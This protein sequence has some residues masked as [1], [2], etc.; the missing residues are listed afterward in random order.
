MSRLT[1]QT[2]GLD[3]QDLY[4][5]QHRQA[6]ACEQLAGLKVLELLC[7]HG[8][9][10]AALMSI[11]AEVDGIDPDGDAINRAK[12]LHGNLGSLVFHTANLDNLPFVDGV[13]DAVVSFSDLAQA[14]RR[15]ALIEEMRRV[16]KPE[17]F[18]LVCLDATVGTDIDAWEGALSK[19]FSGVAAY[20]QRIVAASSLAPL[21][22][23]RPAPNG[24]D[25]RGYR[26]IL[27]GGNPSK[28]GP[29]V[30]RFNDPTSFVYLASNAPLPHIDGP[31]S[32]F[33]ME[34]IDLWA[35]RTQTE[36]RKSKPDDLK[37]EL[38]MAR[39]KIAT[40][41][42]TRDSLERVLAGR[43]EGVSGARS[44]DLS[45]AR[46]MMEELA[47]KPVPADV[48]NLIKLLGQIGVDNT[49][50]DMRLS[51]AHKEI[52]A[53]TAAQ[54]DLISNLEAISADAERQAVLLRDAA[55]KCEEVSAILAEQIKQ[56]S[57]LLTEILQDLDQ[58][59]ERESVAVQ[60][61]R[62]LAA[63]SDELEALLARGRVIEREFAVERQALS[64]QI[65]QLELSLTSAHAAKHAIEESRVEAA[66]AKEAAEYHMAAAL[67][68]IQGA[69]SREHDFRIEISKRTEVESQL[70][71]T[72][73]QVT[74]DLALAQ[75][76]RRGQADEILQLREAKDQVDSRFAALQ[77]G[78]VQQ[79]ARTAEV[80]ETARQTELRLRTSNEAVEALN[81][82]LV[83]AAG[84]E[85][86]LLEQRK[87]WELEKPA[88]ETRQQAWTEER[89][90]W[91]AAQKSERETLETERK[92]W[93]A[94]KTASN[95]ERERLKHAL[96]VANAE[97]MAW[98]AELSA[99]RLERQAW[100]S[101]RTIHVA[102]REASRLEHKSW[103]E[104]RNQLTKA[105][106]EASERADACAKSLLTARWWTR[107]GRFTQK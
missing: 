58:A 35:K 32:I 8:D 43:A 93:L 87:V 50:Q 38:E 20:S 7:G 28:T 68:D 19:R 26:T 14:G 17:G 86:T 10:S 13:F 15:G 29:G 24:T 16:L 21:H 81:T 18:A 88:W 48:P 3:G 1:N 103:H 77:R 65:I 51:A 96:E 71:E 101:E 84:T 80:E 105:V 12:A 49:K 99:L 25:Y 61:N 73:R 6:F 54:R 98:D 69:I 45:V 79:E 82:R 83:A 70:H 92:T 39:A 74:D 41:V 75:E 47:G 53:L 60:A 46:P 102:E 34:S 104:E 37:N 85:L 22:A 36:P 44:H 107:L 57:E 63:K 59:A 106:A 90:R 30:V 27:H 76:V 67:A 78:L 9:A 42:E 100:N 64:D 11:A 52:S 95:A 31:D 55:A 56:Q 97:K 62:D 94:E 33:L 23:K 91:E 5:R 66:T 89:Q 4:G 2:R 40:L 72:L